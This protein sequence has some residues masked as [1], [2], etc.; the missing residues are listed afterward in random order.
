MFNHTVRGFSL[1]II[2][3]SDRSWSESFVFQ[4]TLTSMLVMLLNMNKITLLA[5]MVSPV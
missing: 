1:V 2:Y 5:V 3:R 4:R